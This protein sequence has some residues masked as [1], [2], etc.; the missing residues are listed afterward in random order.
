M[1][2]HPKIPLEKVIPRASP[3]A[4]KL[5]EWMLQYNPKNRPRPSQILAHEF[6]KTKPLIGT[7]Q[8]KTG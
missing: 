8:L 5:M 4:I 2:D 6:F 1:P 3:D 7:A